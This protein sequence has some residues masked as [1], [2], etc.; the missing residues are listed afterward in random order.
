MILS[1]RTWIVLGVVVV[2]VIYLARALGVATIAG[3]DVPSG[4][5][6]DSL[7]GEDASGN[8]VRGYFRNPS[9]DVCQPALDAVRGLVPDWGRLGI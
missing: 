6:P 9:T 7:F 8:C 3:S 2:A 4:F 5:G 1:L